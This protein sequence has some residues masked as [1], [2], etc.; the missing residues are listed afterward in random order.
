MKR[1]VKPAPSTLSGKLTNS[2]SKY[3]KLNRWE[4]LAA[5]QA[6]SIYNIIRLDEGESDCNNFDSLLV[7]AVTVR[8]IL[9]LSYYLSS[10]M[11]PKVVSKQMNDPKIVDRAQTKQGSCSLETG[12]KNWIFEESCRR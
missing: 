12:W 6:L 10:N 5:L 2:S 4:L 1:S 9:A 11:T 3:L 8:Q 7:K